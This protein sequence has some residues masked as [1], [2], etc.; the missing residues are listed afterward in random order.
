LTQKPERFCHNST[1]NLKGWQDR[2]DHLG[3]D[4]YEFLFT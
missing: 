4:A 3:D 1:C 2:V